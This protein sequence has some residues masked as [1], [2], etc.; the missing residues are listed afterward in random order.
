MDEPDRAVAARPLARRAL[1]TLGVRGDAPGAELQL[2]DVCAAGGPVA[3]ACVVVQWLDEN[4]MLLDPQG[5]IDP[6]ILRLEGLVGH[7]STY[8]FVAVT[9]I[10]EPSTVIMLFTAA[11]VLAAWRRRCR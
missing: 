9:P 7:F 8:S 11:A 6:A 5:G 3:D 1:L 2:F 4:R 10:P